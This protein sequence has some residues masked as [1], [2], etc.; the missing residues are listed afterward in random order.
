MSEIVPFTDLAATTREVRD[1]VGDAWQHLLETSSFVG[2]QAVDSFERAWAAYCGTSDAVGVGNGTDAVRLTLAALGIGA[3]DE[4]IVPA[5]TFIASA[6]AV[7]LVGAEPRFT[8]VDPATLLLSPDT[9]RAAIT[10]RTRA[11]LVVHLYGQVPDM[12]SLGRAAAEA[13]LAIIEDAAQAHGAAWRDRRAGAMGRAGCFSFYPAKNLGAFGDA[14]AVVTSDAQLAQRIRCLRDHGRAAGSH[15]RHKIVGT[16]SRLDAIQAAV[17]TAKLVKLEGWTQARRSIAARYRD[18]FT[19]GPVQLVD[20]LPSARGAY[21]L[22][23]VRARD[24]GIV[25]QR[26]ASLGI[27]TRIHYPLPCHQQVPYRGYASGRLPVAEQ[28]AAEVLS[29]PIF[30]QMTDAQV[31]RVCEAVHR[32]CAA[33]QRRVA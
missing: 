19:D 26:L 24:R 1:A 2:G 25:R 6:E 33:G 32:A 8:D 29:L 4:V 31:A 28:A 20:E 23:V 18:A 16:N 5:N 15:E 11:V 14:G 30:P 3:G 17:L 7:V 12:D 10:G 22:A 21:H 13:G 27:E 9:L